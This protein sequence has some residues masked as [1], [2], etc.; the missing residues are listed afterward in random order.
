MGKGK[1]GEGVDVEVIEVGPYISHSPNRKLA[2]YCLFCRISARSSFRHL[3]SLHISLE[4]DLRS[5]CLFRAWYH[6]C[7]KVSPSYASSTSS[8]TS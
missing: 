6:T 1:D 7:D 2:D 5:F 8:C 3:P 4:A